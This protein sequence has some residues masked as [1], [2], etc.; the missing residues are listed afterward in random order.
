LIAD[1]LGE[2]RDFQEM[3]LVLLIPFSGYLENLL[4]VRIYG[5]Q[6]G[7]GSKRRAKWLQSMQSM[8]YVQSPMVQG[9]EQKNEEQ[10]CQKRPLL[11]FHVLIAILRLLRVLKHHRLPPD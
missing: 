11:E 9:K 8:Y 2:T 7:I 10:G 3:T 5:V 1:L 6:T 4:I